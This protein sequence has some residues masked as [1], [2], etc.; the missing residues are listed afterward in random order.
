LGGRADLQ[1]LGLFATSA[2]ALLLISFALILPR[3]RPASAAPSCRRCP[4]RFHLAGPLSG[5]ACGD[6]AS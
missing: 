5:D 1:R 3:R 2:I 4:G 6:G